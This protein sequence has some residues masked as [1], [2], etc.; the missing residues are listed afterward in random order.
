MTTMITPNVGQKTKTKRNYVEDHARRTLRNA[1]LTPEQAA[2]V[3]RAMKAAPGYPEIK[4]NE[5]SRKIP[6]RL[7]GKLHKL[8]GCG[9]VWSAA[10]QELGLK[11]GYFRELY[12]QHLEEL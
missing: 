4:L 12:N 9:L 5:L 8:I 11:A 2:N 7:G 6:K 3:V 1:G 10:E